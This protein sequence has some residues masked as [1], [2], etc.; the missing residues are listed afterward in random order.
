MTIKQVKKLTNE[1]LRTKII[2]ICGY[3]P[4][5]LSGPFGGKPDFLYDINK[6]QPLELVPQYAHDLNVMHEMEKNIRDQV[7]QIHYIDYLMEIAG[8]NS[9]FGT[10]SATAKQRAQAF[11]LT[12]VNK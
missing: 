8:E 11:I 6:D 1:Q 9:P 4:F 7:K 10:I 3:K 5:Y 12:M 2:L